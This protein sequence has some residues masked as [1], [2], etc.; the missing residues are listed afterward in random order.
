[1]A[2]DHPFVLPVFYLPYPARLN[3][4]VEGARVH[5]RVWAKEMGMLDAPA[6]GGGVI[7]DEAELDRHDYGLLCAYTHPDCDAPA[8]DLITDWYVWVFFF[9]DHFLDAF[10]RTRDT[11]GAKA[12]LDRIP[13]FMPLDV[14]ETPEPENPVELGLLDLWRRTA[15]AMSTGWRKRFLAS[16]VNL[17]FESLWELDNITSDRV[18]NPIEY[19]EMR[20]K[21]GGAPWSAGLVEYAVGAEVPDQ[22]AAS[23]PLAVL[24]DTF[25]DAVHLRNDLFSYEREVASEGENANAV[26]VFE[27]F[28]GLETQRAAELVND[29][30]T[31]RLHQFENTAL[32]EIPVLCAAEGVA[33]PE[34]LAIALYAKGLQDWQA[35]GHE[36]HMRSS[37]YMN[38]T[39]VSGM[40]HSVLTGPNGIGTSQARIAAS[41]LKQHSRAPFRVVGPTALPDFH[42]PF[43]LRLNPHLDEARRHAVEWA[44][45]MGFLAPDPALPGSGLWDRRRFL[46][47]DFALCS[48]GIDPDGTAEELNASADWLAWGTY[49]DD[50]YPAVFTR[51][52]G[53]GAAIAQH[54]RLLE[55]M[56]VD[57]GPTPV[58]ANPVELGL[59]DLWRRTA[60]GFDDRAR[61]EFRRAVEKMLEGWLWEVHAESQNRVPDPVDYVEM[62][63]DSFGSDLTMSLARLRKG[64]TIPD[65]VWR[66]RPIGWMEAAAMDAVCLLNDV[67]S[68]QKEVEYEGQLLN[69][70]VVIEE[71]L[72]VG[73]E[74]AVRIAADLANARIEQ[75]QLVEATGLPGLVAEHDLDAEAQ[76]ALASYVADLKHWIAAIHKWHLDGTDRYREENLRRPL[77]AGPGSTA[78]YSVRRHLGA[79]APEAP[80][81]A[82]F[83]VPGPPSWRDYLPP[84]PENAAPAPSAAT[85]ANTAAAMRFL[86]AEESSSGSAATAAASSTASPSGSGPGST[87]GSAAAL[88]GDSAGAGSVAA[89]SGDGSGGAGAGG[90]DSAGV[91]TG[92]GDDGSGGV[93]SAGGVGGVGSGGGLEGDGG[94]EGEGSGGCVGHSSSGGRSGRSMIGSSMQIWTPS[95]TWARAPSSSAAAASA[96]GPVPE[97]SAR[98]EETVTAA[99]AMTKA[100]RRRTYPTAP[101]CVVH[102]GSYCLFC[103]TKSGEINGHLAPGTPVHPFG[104]SGGVRG[105]RAPPAVRPADGPDP[106]Q[107]AGDHD[108][109]A[110]HRPLRDRARVRPHHRLGE[111]GGGRA[112]DL[113]GGERAGRRVLGGGRA[114]AGAARRGARGGAGLHDRGHRG[115]VAGDARPGAGVGRGAHAAGRDAG[116]GGGGA[117]GRRRGAGAADGRGGRGHGDHGVPHG[118]AA[119]GA[120]GAERG[121]VDGAGAGGDPGVRGDAHA[122]DA[123]A[124]V[125]VRAGGAH[126]GDGGAHAVRDVPAGVPV[127]PQRGDGPGGVRDGDGPLRLHRRELC[128]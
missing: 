103:F 85:N 68:Y 46:G 127:Q 121:D 83:R 48:A 78:A 32:T 93:G 17:L 51:G 96:S 92:S 67:C 60:A 16:T 98:P 33:P 22:V 71:Y 117:D 90:S 28:L 55:C 1:M 2:E 42:Q 106:Q 118:P 82:Q 113:P 88:V 39:A 77:D 18:A 119:P 34:Q 124:E 76:A 31:S 116:T 23:R 13:L 120:A 87:G 40:P 75:F 108:L 115:R 24:R 45:A 41:A 11:A 69:G 59:A 37:R 95:P 94:A 86:S 29:I 73:P 91:V 7:W 110:P 20:R 38:S 65:A 122:R 89:G 100:T 61:A 30:L 84:R 21:V 123:D 81:P 111:Q 72:E 53:L 79:G 50:Y 12:Y 56:P 8:L 36:W 3:P 6:A 107:R 64:R 52:R 27:R 105:D 66:S 25:S 35:G 26:L 99:A 80:A 15:P 97:A 63:R 19:I 62:R 102:H 49:G 70:V 74:E 109:R 9:D 4:H 54:R 57:L 58:P 14:G 128:A 125:P 47:F 44:A 126:L 43:E 10:K 101:R 5:A 104:R 112:G 114:R